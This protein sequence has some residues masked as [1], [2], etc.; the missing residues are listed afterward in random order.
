[1][2]LSF[3]RVLFFFFIP[4]FLSAQETHQWT[5][6]KV[7]LKGSLLAKDRFL[8]YYLFEPG[9]IFEEDKHKHSVA[10]IQ[11][12][13]INEGYLD[14]QVSDS[15]AHDQK[16]KTVAIT[17][18][19][20]AGKRFTN[21]QIHIV[22]TSDA[23]EQQERTALTDEMQKMVERD[24]RG[25]FYARQ[26]IDKE[27]Q[28]IRSAL[29]K[30]GYVQPKILLTT[31][32]DK[33][34]SVVNITYTL[35]LRRKLLFSFEG[36]ASF[37]TEKLSD[38]IYALEQEGI[39]LLPALIAEDIETLYK[40]KGFFGVSVTWAEKVGKIT[41][42]IKE[43]PR[44]RIGE[45]GMLLKKSVRINE[46]GPELV[47]LEPS[48]DTIMKK[49]TADIMALGFYDEDALNKILNDV[50]AELVDGG[51]WDVVIYKSITNA[52]IEIDTILGQRRMIQNVEIEG[53]PGT[54]PRGAF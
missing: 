17:L 16:A 20:N 36:N 30:A 8:Q 50:S 14:A 41:F 34:K 47:H 45:Q 15:L 32:Q 19:L 13:L 29:I 10:N 44:T 37:S 21:G 54:I 35:D 18:T 53:Y 46:N 40:K 24:L 1:M 7:K 12:E 26:I 23:I 5:F 3:Y 33:K 31:E 28:K 25:A 49:M 43:G 9:D 52:L 38:E 6:V 51:Y 39:S 4:V 48:V 42:I 11:K 22:I 27:G 2:R